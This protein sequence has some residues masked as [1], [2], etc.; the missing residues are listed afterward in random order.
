MKIM[1]QLTTELAPESACSLNCGT[2]KQLTGPVADAIEERPQ[3]IC[4]AKRSVLCCLPGPI[5][6]SF[7]SP[8]CPGDFLAA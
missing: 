5:D 1:R 6:P 2:S 8:F 3:A 7:L 4:S